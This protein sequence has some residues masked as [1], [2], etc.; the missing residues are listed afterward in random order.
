VKSGVAQQRPSSSP[1]NATYVYC[2]V[3]SKTRPSLRGAPDSVP[4]AGS[5][6]LLPIDREIWAAVADAPLEHF[7]GD[8]LQ[9]EMQ[10][11]EGISRHAF[12]HASVI[13]FFFRRSP[14]IPLKLFTLFSSDERVMVH[15]RSRLATLKRMFASL[16]GREEWAVRII[17][18]EMAREAARA[19]DSGRAYLTLKKRLHQQSSTA[20]PKTVR[21]MDAALRSLGRVAVKSRKETFPAAAKGRPYVAGAS[22]LVDAKRRGA[23]TKQINSITAAMDEAGHRLEVSGPWPPYHF[24]SR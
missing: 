11:V 20:S 17:A 15:V 6:R 21:A 12:A 13:E 14:V 24:V 9:Q 8:A 10:E 2:L 18:G 4:G 5:L 3:H 22:F 16:G 19:L 1:A 23:W 7:A